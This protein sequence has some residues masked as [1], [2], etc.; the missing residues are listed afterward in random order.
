[1]LALVTNQ[2]LRRGER[3]ALR[4]AVDGTMEIFHLERLTAILDQPKMY[5][6]REQFLSIAVPDGSL[7]RE[8][9]LEKLRRASLARSER[10]R[11]WTGSV[12]S[13]W[14]RRSL[15]K[16]GFERS[17][18]TIL[19]RAALARRSTSTAAAVSRS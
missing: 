2:E 1:M 11:D 13:G 16:E 3:K 10:S 17:H 8:A 5:G 15:Q 18:E 19:V 4:G 9:R 6:V 12:A 7:D 14:S